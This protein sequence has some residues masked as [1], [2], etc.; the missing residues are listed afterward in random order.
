MARITMFEARTCLVSQ[1][2]AQCDRY[3]DAARPDGNRKGQGLKGMLQGIFEGSRS[4]LC[5]GRGDLLVEQTP[6]SRRQEQPAGDLN[7]R[8][9]DAK[10]GQDFASE[11]ERHGQQSES[12]CRYFPCQHL[13]SRL[14]VV[15][16]QAQEDWSI[17]N[18]VDHREQC[19]KHHC[20]YLDK[21]DWIHPSAPAESS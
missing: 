5:R 15:P 3:G 14:R 18:W 17:S 20:K 16:R 13:L 10:K 6:A 8:Q 9:A 1:M 2:R 12:V 11:Q 4:F 7:D 21:V 19:G